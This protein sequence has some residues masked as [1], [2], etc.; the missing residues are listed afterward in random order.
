VN[1]PH[2]PSLIMLA[3]FAFT[4]PGNFADFEVENS[5]EVLY[6][7]C[8]CCSESCNRRCP[9]RLCQEHDRW[10]CTGYPDAADWFVQL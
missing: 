7:C 2:W 1:R 10:G 9:D 8:Y 3:K 4:K 5:D 6:S